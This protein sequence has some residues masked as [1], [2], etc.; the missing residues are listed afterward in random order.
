MTPVL[1]GQYTGSITFYETPDIYIW[2]TVLLNTESPKATDTIELS[3]QIRQ[4]LAFDIN[5][6]N[7]LDTQVIFEVIINGEGLI[8]E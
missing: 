7:P 2:Y 4:A 5:L 3:T 1:S 6:Q 8:G